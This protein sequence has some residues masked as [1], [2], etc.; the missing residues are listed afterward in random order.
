VALDV[1]VSQSRSALLLATGVEK[2]GEGVVAEE[3]S[4]APEG[5]T[6]EGE[7]VHGRGKEQHPRNDEATPKKPHE[8]PFLRPLAE[9]GAR[10]E[11]LKPQTSSGTADVASSG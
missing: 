1:L 3:G 11:E 9:V 8:L 4:P 6:V 5:A 7:E 10:V 2:E